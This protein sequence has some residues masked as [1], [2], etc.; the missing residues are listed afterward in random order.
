[1]SV[2]LAD[3]KGSGD[4]VSGDTRLDYRVSGRQQGHDGNH[5]RTKHA[6][7]TGN[8]P[9]VAQLGAHSR[10]ENGECPLCTKFHIYEGK[11]FSSQQRY[12]NTLLWHTRTVFF[13]VSKS[14]YAVPRLVSFR[15][16]KDCSLIMVHTFVSDSLVEQISTAGSGSSEERSILCSFAAQSKLCDIPVAQIRR[17]LRRVQGQSGQAIKQTVSGAPRKKI[18]LYLSF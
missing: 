15:P 1:M 9:S 18:V 7:R 17:E 13:S 6:H 16:L 3:H 11:L 8:R 14:W 4:P 12:A 2:R 5:G 10:F